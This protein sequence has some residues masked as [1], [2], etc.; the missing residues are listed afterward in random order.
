M[1]P[2]DKT[3]KFAEHFQSS[4]LKVMVCGFDIFLFIGPEQHEQLHKLYFI[5]CIYF[6][7]N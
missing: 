2:S 1:I 4:F 3:N 6:F 5:A 7:S